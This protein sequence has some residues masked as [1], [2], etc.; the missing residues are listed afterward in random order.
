MSATDVTLLSGL[1]SREPMP[2]RGARP[3]RANV[4]AIVLAGVHAWGENLL[5]RVI[6]RPLVRVAARP[7]VCHTLAWLR[8]GGIENASICANSDTVHLRRRLGDGRPLDIQLDYYEDVMPRGPAGCARDVA[9]GSDADTFLV[10]EGTIL[11]RIDVDD[12]LRA[13]TTSGAV[14]TVVVAASRTGDAGQAL[15][16]AGIYVFSRAAFEYV[17]SGGYQDIKETLIPRLHARGERVCTYVVDSIATPAVKGIASY[18]AV[19]EW[20]VEQLVRQPAPPGYVRRDQ[21]CIH[22]TARVHPDARIVGPAWI[23]ARAR[24]GA[25]ALIIGPVTIG[26]DSRIGRGAVVSRSSIWERCCVGPD[27]VLDQCILTDGSSCVATAG[28]VRHQVVA[29]RRRQ[30]HSLLRRLL[31]E[32]GQPN[33]M[34][35][36]LENLRREE[37]VVR[38]AA[39]A[40]PA[41]DSW[42]VGAETPAFK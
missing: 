34:L 39:L 37:R 19:S 32:R 9:V 38:H 42:E 30:R 36:E 16:P 23:E 3:S 15:E 11:P 26:A 24:I 8:T 14:L 6:C 18:L 22:V 2:E 5:E 35:E 20:A 1:V 17:P 33:P 12:L 29:P 41:V 27:A 4:H 21:A 13:H 7:L 25:G 10:V 40:S 28:P 31:P